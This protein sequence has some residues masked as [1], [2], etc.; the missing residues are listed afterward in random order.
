MTAKEVVHLLISQLPD[1]CSLEEILYR[2]ETRKKID[3]GIAAA[4]R[5]EVYTHEEVCAMMDQWE[6]V[7][8]GPGLR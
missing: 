4:E 3:E 8:F 7:S 2:I 5:G 1:D 6:N